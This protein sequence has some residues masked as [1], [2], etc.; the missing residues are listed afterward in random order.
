MG[1]EKPDRADSNRRD[2]YK[3]GKGL[4]ESTPRQ[5]L[6]DF[7]APSSRD[8]LAII[9]TTLSD[10]LPSLRPLRGELMAE[11]AFAFL[12]GTADVSAFDMA[13]QRAPGIRVQAGG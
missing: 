1:Y 2:L 8:P 11:S 12:R 10:R 9:E 7:E 13:H 6:A 3:L 5:A 4:R